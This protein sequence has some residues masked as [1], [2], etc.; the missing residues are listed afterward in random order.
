M[1]LLRSSRLVSWS[2][3]AQERGA[4][5][6]AQAGV[7]GST[8]LTPSDETSGR[9]PRMVPVLFPSTLF[10]RCC[11]CLALDAQFPSFLGVVRRWQVSQ[12]ET[13]SPRCGTLVVTRSRVASSEDVVTKPDRGESCCRITLPF[14]DAD[15]FLLERDQLKFVDRDAL[16]QCE[17]QVILWRTLRARTFLTLFS[18]TPTVCESAA[19]LA[20]P[21]LCC[22]PFVLVICYVCPKIPACRF[23]RVSSGSVR[24][25]PFLLVDGFLPPRTTLL[26]RIDSAL[27][28]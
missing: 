3:L 7:S 1:L 19:R 18:L 6:G 23:S 5:A 20:C 24:T 8:G 22:T 10:H 4:Q 27:A 13:V 2:F 21:P 16:Q 26:L 17:K 11:D 15:F 12:S 25:Q 14:I 28:V 9:R